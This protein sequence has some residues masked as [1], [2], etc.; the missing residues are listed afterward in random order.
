MSVEFLTMEWAL[1]ISRNYF[2]VS[3]KVCDNITVI[4]SNIT[5]DTVGLKR[6]FIIYRPN[7]I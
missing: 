7:G 4:I 1:F 5:L 3:V 2:V 6:R